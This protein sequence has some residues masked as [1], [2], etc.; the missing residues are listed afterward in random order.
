MDRTIVNRTGKVKIF[1]EKILASKQ[2]KKYRPMKKMIPKLKN[3]TSKISSCLLVLIY[4][5]N[6]TRF[7]IILSSFFLSSFF[8]VTLITTKF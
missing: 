7:V 5:Y 3:L 6:K 2:E 4:L 8:F 1:I